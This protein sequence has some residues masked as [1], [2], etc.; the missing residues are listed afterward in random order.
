MFNLFKERPGDVKKIRAALL[1][2]I[3]EKLQRSEGGE[4]VNI[5]GIYLY[6]NCSDSDRYLYEGAVFS[7]VPGKFRDE[8]QRI[9]DDYAISL[10]SAW[11]LEI[12]FTDQY[13]AQSYTSYELNAALFIST[14][15]AG[16]IQKKA[17]AFLKILSGHAEKEVYVIG[18]SQEKI[19]IGREAK[20]QLAGGFVRKNTIA[21]TS[22]GSMEMNRS[23]SRQ[24]AH[25]EWESGSGSFL[26]FA[27]EG[28]IPPNNKMK[29]RSADGISVK[30][31]A[32]EVGH[33]LQE[34]DQIILGDT[35]VLE[36]TYF[37][38]DK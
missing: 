19:N 34:G 36:F 22:S 8:I 2:F 38:D 32:I 10:P 7:N 25:I 31:Q 27:D 9:A 4:G 11:K 30:M 12:E 37:G 15:K 23:I 20:A 1:Q 5:N 13:P 24:H 3:K 21:F 14:R 33:R 29:I 17:K 26:V 18:P 6:F 28:G 16:I 35:A